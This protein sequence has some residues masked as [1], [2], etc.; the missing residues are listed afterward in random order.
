M[1]LF[2]LVNQDQKKS[3][4]IFDVVQTPK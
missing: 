3:I 4:E 2:M 1:S